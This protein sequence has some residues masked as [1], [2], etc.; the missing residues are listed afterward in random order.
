M[1]NRV[2]LV[3]SSVPF[4]AINSAKRVF[5][6]GGGS[7]GRFTGTGDLDR[8]IS[9]ICG[10]NWNVLFEA[11]EQSVNEIMHNRAHKE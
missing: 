7:G 8:S 11:L 5:G 9:F 3:D 10:R 6:F 4:E 1:W 2:G